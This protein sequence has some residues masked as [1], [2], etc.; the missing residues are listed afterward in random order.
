[1]TLKV[2]VNEFFCALVFPLIRDLDA[3]F[4][5]KCITYKIG[6]IDIILSFKKR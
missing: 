4:Y 5:V 3:E 6:S 2:S 1:M